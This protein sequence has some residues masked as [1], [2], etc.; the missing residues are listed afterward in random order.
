MA[1]S[2]DAR[3]R[4]RR[5]DPR[6]EPGRRPPCW[7]THRNPLQP[8]RRSF[9]PG[10][11]AAAPPSPRPA[12]GPARR[13]SRGPRDARPGASAS[14]HTPRSAPVIVSSVA[15]TPAGAA[16][17]RCSRCSSMCT[18]AS[19]VSA[20][21]AGLE[22]GGGADRP[23]LVADREVHRPDP[24]RPHRHLQR[25]IDQSQL[26]LVGDVHLGDQQ[27]DRRD[28]VTERLQQE[29]DSGLFED[30]DHG[31]VVDVLVHVDVRPPHMYRR[32]EAVLPCHAVLSITRWSPFH[33]SWSCC[34]SGGPPPTTWPG[35]AR[36]SRRAR[37]ACD[38]PG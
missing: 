36:R 1:A 20:I 27:P 18:A 17:S 31:R 22:S 34:G 10:A 8:R 35:R 23:H 24:L 38:A 32:R 11:P 15:D 5:T 28:L 25:R 29:R 9:R 33:S 19:C 3:R 37:S 2:P 6:A 26:R 14:S 7:P 21:T 16:E 12:A 30:R 13:T 4:H